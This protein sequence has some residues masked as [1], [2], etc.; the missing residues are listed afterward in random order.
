[1]NIFE[2]KVSQ[3]QSGELEMYRY[4]PPQDSGTEESVAIGFEGPGLWGPVKGFLAL[5]KQMRT[6]RGITFYE[7]EETPG[8][9]AEI[10]SKNFRKQFVGLDITHPVEYVR[11]KKPQEPYQI[12]AITGATI[13]SRAVV[14][15]LNKRIEEV[16]K[17]LKV[18]K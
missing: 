5:D 10:A 7:Q 12:E 17:I 11:N 13:S 6:I 9:G 8:L 3:E 16:R 4:I 1:M 14:N 18:G 2:D 15:L